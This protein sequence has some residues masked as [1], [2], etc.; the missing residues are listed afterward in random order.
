MRFASFLGFALGLL[1]CAVEPALALTPEDVINTVGTD[2]EDA[3][4][5]EDEVGGVAGALASKMIP[6]ANTVAIL[7]II[8]AGIVM[9]ISQDEEQITMM[10]RTFIFSIVALLFIFTAGV[11]RDA[12]LGGPT[13]S[14][15]TDGS[16][17][18]GFLEDPTNAAQVITDELFGIMA[19]VSGA[20]APLAVLMIIMSG[21]RA[22]TTYNSEEGIAQIRRTVF[23]CIFGLF[24][25]FTRYIV[26]GTILVNNLGVPTGNVSAI[27]AEIIIAMNKALAFVAMFAVGMIILAGIFMIA[28]VGNDEQYQKARGLILRTT[29][30]VIVIVTSLGLVNIIFIGAAS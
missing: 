23:S 26:S 14:G 17:T 29:I 13:L 16:V 9:A 5:G 19:W 21:I 15:S 2:L 8:I 27:I 11:V 12:I 25:V 6:I 22:V 10:R 1:V 4:D 3:F 7:M 20:L 30:C 24:L 18:T 28:N